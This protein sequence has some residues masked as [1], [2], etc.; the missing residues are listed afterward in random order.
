MSTSIE[1][2]TANH[3]ETTTASIKNADKEKTVDVSAN[4]PKYIK[5]SKFEELC[6]WLLKWGFK[7]IDK[8]GKNTVL[9]I[10]FQA[11][12]FP[13]IPYSSGLNTPF[14]LEFQDDLDDGFIIR[15]T[16]ELD[17]NIE[18]FLN[19]QNR[20]REIEL[21]YIE[22][23]HLV[24]PLRISIIRDHPY[25]KL[26][27]VIFSDNLQKQFFLD[28]IHDLINSM[29]I[30]IGKWDQRYYQSRPSEYKAIKDR[31]INDPEL[32]RK[33]NDPEL[34]KILKN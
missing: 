34:D 20:A 32:D 23:N 16:F 9:G 24:L 27:K 26:Y 19:S 6:G 15:T 29:T 14:Y 30:I 18:I 22:I 12:V 25:I 3:D 13:Q 4:S 31:K 10:E 21:T 8:S 33:I 2:K 1:Q 28:S 5:K 7:V 17:K 11:E